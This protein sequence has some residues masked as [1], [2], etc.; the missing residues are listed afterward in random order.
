MTESEKMKWDLSQLVEFDDPGYIEEQLIASAKAAQ[1]FSERHR[2]KIS[3]YD[4]KMLLDALQDIDRERLQ[5]EGATMYAR[6]MYDAD[7]HDDVAK[8]LADKG[9]NAA[10]LIGQ[11]FAFA[12]I[13]LGVLL[14]DNPEIAN[15][16]LLSEYKHFLE[17]IKRRI[18]HMLTEAEE[19]IIIAKDKNGVNSW[20]QLH[21]D[22]L[23]TRTYEIEIDGEAKNLPYS[24]IIQ[25]YQHPDRDLRKRVHEVVYCPNS[26][27]R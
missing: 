2:G 18:P 19:R 4:A 21:G 25:Y 6:R 9:R 20:S 16:P 8:K 22:W 26:S 13:E 11:A 24:E 14:S 15:D 17:K 7:M 12:P 10:M 27:A 3:S 23:A 1:E 5:Y